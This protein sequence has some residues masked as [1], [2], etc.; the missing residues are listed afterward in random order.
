MDPKGTVVDSPATSFEIDR[1]RSIPTVIGESMCKEDSRVKSLSQTLSK[2]RCNLRTN[3]CT[4]QKLEETFGRQ[5]HQGRIHS[6]ANG[7]LMIKCSKDT[8]RSVATRTQSPN[9]YMYSNGLENGI[10]HH[11]R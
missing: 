2:S 9:Q 6:P 1:V 7:Q 11:L 10:H 8:F 4:Q 5:E 3:S